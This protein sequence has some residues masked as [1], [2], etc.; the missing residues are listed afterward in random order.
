MI[1][2]DFGLGEDVDL[3]REAVRSF[4]GDLIAPRAAEIDAKKRVPPR[5]LAT[6]R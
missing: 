3:L 1:D 5:P 6:T 2:F 4:A